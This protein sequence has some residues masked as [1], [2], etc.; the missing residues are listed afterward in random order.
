MQDER[1]MIFARFWNLRRADAI[2]AGPIGL[3]ER[4]RLAFAA[5]RPGRFQRTRCAG[6]A[7]SCGAGDAPAHY[8]TTM[9]ARHAE[10]PGCT[11]GGVCRINGNCGRHELKEN[12]N[13]TVN[14][15]MVPS[16]IVGDRESTVG[17]VREL[18]ERS[19]VHALPIVGEDGHP[20]GIVTSTDV[21]GDVPAEMPVSEVMSHKVYTVPRYDGIHIAARVMRNHK[22]HHVVVTEEQKVVGILSTFDMLRLVED[23]RFTMKNAP[24]ESKRKGAKRK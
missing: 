11:C 2:A 20:V 17:E 4:P 8:V 5:E 1:C 13:V 10:H 3:G 22:L 24:Q 9:N 21:L 12:M 15:L 7:R 16:V 14:D 6:S 19:D 23:H 18:M